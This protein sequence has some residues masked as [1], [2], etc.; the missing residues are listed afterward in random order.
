[1]SCCLERSSWKILFVKG[2][3]F[4]RKQE[5]KG[6]FSWYWET[7]VFLKDRSKMVDSWKTDGWPEGTLT[8]DLVCWSPQRLLLATAVKFSGENDKL[9]VTCVLFIVRKELEDLILMEIN[10]WIQSEIDNSFGSLVIKIGMVLVPIMLAYLRISV[11]S[12]NTESYSSR[13]ILF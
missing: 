4:L 13:V 1:M 11:Y 5:E 10:Y 3:S 9:S 12:L 8:P 6:R 7:K 2:S